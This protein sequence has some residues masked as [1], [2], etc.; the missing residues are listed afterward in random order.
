VDVGSTRLNFED[1]GGDAYQLINAAGTAL[2]DAAGQNINGVNLDTN[3]ATNGFAMYEAAPAL[4]P[5]NPS[6]TWAVSIGRAPSSADT[7]NNRNDFHID[8]SPTP[9]MPNDLVNFTVTA[10]TPDDTPAATAASTSI[11]VTGTDFAPGMTVRVGAAGTGPICS[12]ITNSTLATCSVLPSTGSVGQVN[13]TF[14]DPASVGVPNVVLSNVFTYTGTDNEM[15][16]PMEADSCNLQFPPSFTVTGN[17]QTPLIF[18]RISEAGVTE[19]GGAPAGILAEVGYGPYSGTS[20]TDPRT[21]ATW[22]FFPANY[23]Q[24]VGNDDEFMNTLLAPNVTASTTFAYTFRFSQDNGMRW[25]YCDLDG[26]GS[27]AGLMFDTSQ[28]GVMTVTP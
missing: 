13:L 1:L 23:N 2:L 25:T 11:T 10:I 9:G 3:T 7:G 16:T 12:T 21:S 28:L 20:P 8:P 19:P 27:N 18:G 4:S 6:G 5:L 22:R 26:A 24:Q 14:V 15:D 17:T